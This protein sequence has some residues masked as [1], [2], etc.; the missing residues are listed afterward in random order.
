MPFSE[1]QLSPAPNPAYAESWM[2]SAEGGSKGTLPASLLTRPDPAPS[3]PQDTHPQTQAFFCPFRT[4][5]LGQ[6]TDLPVHIG[7]TVTTILLLFN[8]TSTM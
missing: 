4:S 5:P 3:Q 8:L 7:T 2:A 6:I 1:V